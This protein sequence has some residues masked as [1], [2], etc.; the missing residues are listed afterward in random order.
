MRMAAVAGASRWRLVVLVV[1]LMTPAV[2]A[3][4]IDEYLSLLDSYAKDPRRAVDTIIAT[5]VRED[6][7]EAHVTACLPRLVQFAGDVSRCKGPRRALA[8]MLHTEAAVATDVVDDALALFHL[9]QAMRLVPHAGQPGLVEKWFEFAVMFL[10][11]R[12]SVRAAG[13]LAD[14]MASRFPDSAVPH[15]LRGV[16]KE[17]GV[18]FDHKN[19]RDPIPT[20]RAGASAATTLVF[21]VEDYERALRKDAT[22]VEARLRLGRIR[23]LQRRPDADAALSAVALD[24]PRPT[25]R[26]LAHL[27]LGSSAERQGQ[28]EAAQRHYEAALALEP[29]AQTACIA[30]SHVLHLR[31]ELDRATTVALECVAAAGSDDPWWSYRVG[32]YDAQ[33]VDEMRTLA[34]RPW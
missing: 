26:Y 13:D 32:A 5:T 29:R 33:L 23:S 14:G 9:Q 8:V 12:G 28:L 18:M 34:V 19:L 6:T 17:V 2:G 30:I 11:S 7:I 27:F 25:T 21:A 15:Y 4:T 10:L 1:L 20:G 31:A 24:A 22:L 3:Q 16:V